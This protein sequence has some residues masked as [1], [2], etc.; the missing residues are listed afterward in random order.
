MK[1]TFCANGKVDPEYHFFV[2]PSLWNERNLIPMLMNPNFF[3][4]VAPSQ[5][6]K[7]TRTETLMKQLLNMD[8]LPI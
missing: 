1:R 5:S 8:V 7:T 6:S 2:N 3:L 4:L